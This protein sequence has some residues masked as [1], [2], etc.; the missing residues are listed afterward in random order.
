MTELWH[1]EVDETWRSR[2]RVKRSL[3]K[4]AGRL[5]TNTQHKIHQEHEIFAVCAMYNT[6][7]KATRAPRTPH[8]PPFTDGQK[9]GGYAVAQG[10][11][12]IQGQ[13]RNT[14]TITA[15][16]ATAWVRLQASTGFFWGIVWGQ[17]LDGHFTACIFC[18]S[19]KRSYFHVF[20]ITSWRAGVVPC[21][22]ASGWLVC[23]GGITQLNF[24]T[25]Q[26]AELRY[27][28]ISPTGKTLKLGL[29]NWQGQHV[30]LWNV[31]WLRR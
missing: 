21:P 30:Q 31:R 3:W 18:G 29:V 11:H 1:F 4:P 12:K 14:A 25:C 26:G 19:L 9:Q 22:S 16:T 20:P 28:A 2:M 5:P 10:G 8:H 15:K 27:S 6:R 24:K 23:D 13:L 7:T 17:S